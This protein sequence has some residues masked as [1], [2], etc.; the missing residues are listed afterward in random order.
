[1]AKKM[2]MDASQQEETRVVVLDG[3]KVEEYDFDSKRKKQLRGNIYLAKITRVEPSLQAAFVEYGGNRHGFLPFN[4]IHTD[5]YQIPVEDRSALSPSSDKHEDQGQSADNN[6]ETEADVVELGGDDPIKKHKPSSAARSYKIQEVIQRRQILLVQVTKEE[7][8][9]KG[10]ALTTYLSLPGRCCVLMP[11]TIEGGGISRKVSDPEDR[12]RLKEA[13]DEIELSETMSLIIRTAGSK[14]SKQDIKLDYDYLLRLWEE[15]RE[16]T[17]KSLAPQ[18]IYEEGNIIKRS[19]RDLYTRDI[20]EIIVEGKEGYQ[21]AKEFMRQIMPSH[22][23]RVQEY[24][25]SHVPLYHRHNIEKQ[26]DATHDPAV[27]LPSGGYIVINPTEALVAIDVN[28]GQ[29]TR[30]RDIEITATK[31]NIEAAREVARQLRLRDL[32]GLVVIDFIDMDESKNQLSVERTLKE[33]LKND[34]ARIQVGRISPFGLLEL[35]RQRLRPSIMEIGGE[36]CIHCNG[37]GIM[38]TA[39][40]IALQ[41]LRAIEGE[42]IQGGA[43]ELHVNVPTSVALFLLN[44]KREAVGLLEERYTIRIVLKAT[45]DHDGH[46]FSIERIHPKAD[47]DQGGRYRNEPPKKAVIGQEEAE[48]RDPN[49]RRRPRRSGRREQSPEVNS[50]ATR[51]PKSPQQH[52]QK[53]E[54]QT[55]SPA[56]QSSDPIIIESP[57]LREP[58][59]LAPKEPSEAQKSDA[60]KGPKKEERSRNRRNSRGR[61]TSQGGNKATEESAVE[62]TATAASVTKHAS[63][64]TSQK[65]EVTAKAEDNASAKTQPTDS[66]P[67]PEGK[68][69]VRGRRPRAKPGEQNA[70][71]AKAK[72]VRKT[73]FKPR[74]A[75]AD[76]DKTSGKPTVSK[77]DEAKSAPK[78]VTAKDSDSRV[79]NNPAA[80]KVITE[81]AAPA[82]VEKTVPQ[83][84]KSKKTANSERVIDLSTKTPEAKTSNDKKKGWWSNKKS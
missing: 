8:G 80:S 13:L 66:A 32:A 14:R 63:A 62:T 38:R 1:M 83:V 20:D 10:A 29:A 55:S 78:P 51:H 4:E 6:N 11:N 69:P 19:I 67:K 12:K 34:R 22:V 60:E 15:I 75:K 26:L 43:K 33:A 23:K 31:T 45:P 57:S 2:L 39:E 49:R 74:A 9:N 61:Y 68:A 18:L 36:P 40:S 70:E 44:E 17:L 79:A 58:R 21:V 3:N 50:T 28:S 54:Q 72:P 76:E 71:T 56:G 52:A 24:S 53:E 59:I 48:G 81:K 7:R 65:K 46:E 82:L 64:G 77:T 16:Q 25:D 5:Y 37:A 84:E 41:A 35:S 47:R 42:G 30:E 73:T 27:R